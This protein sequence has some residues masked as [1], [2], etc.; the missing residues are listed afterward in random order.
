[1]SGRDDPGTQE[2]VGRE[3]EGS[4]DTLSKTWVIYTP[5]VWCCSQFLPNERSSQVPLEK[6]VSPTQV[7]SI[8][9]LSLPCPLCSQEPCGRALHP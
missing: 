2:T 7:M 4:L 8:W 9:P 6:S 5:L 1:M 3:E